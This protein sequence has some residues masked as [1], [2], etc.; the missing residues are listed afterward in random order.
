LIGRLVGSS[1]RRHYIRAFKLPVESDQSEVL[2][3]PP[4]GYS[5][6]RDR[7]RHRYDPRDRKRDL[8]RDLGA[9]LKITAISHVVFGSDFPFTT[10]TE[11]VEGLQTCGLF[12]ARDLSA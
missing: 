8:Q 2:H 4:R 1:V 9:L 12:N 3:G 5:R 6:P 7:I 10:I 11:N